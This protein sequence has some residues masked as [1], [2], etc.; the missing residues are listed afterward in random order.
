MDDDFKKH[1]LELRNLYVKSTPRQR[2]NI[3]L[4]RIQCPDHD[5]NLLITRVSAVEGVARSLLVHHL[6]PRQND[7]L[8]MYSVFCNCSAPTLVEAYFRAR[9]QKTP[10]DVVGEDT[11]KLFQHAVAYRNLL[12]HECT[13]LG[14]DKTPELLAAS[15]TVL[16]KLA[17]LAGLSTDKI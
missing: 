8:K 1:R 2:L 9:C 4:E 13:Y 3:A 14:Q 7:T 15:R 6:T 16:L 10:H 11:W 17:E 5:P 12:V